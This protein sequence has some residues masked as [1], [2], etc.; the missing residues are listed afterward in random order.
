[1]R[2]LFGIRVWMREQ[3]GIESYKKARSFFD[4][5]QGACVEQRENL[6]TERNRIQPYNTLYPTVSKSH[7]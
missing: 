1:M 6:K 7:Y 2:E 5:S 4:F 3:E